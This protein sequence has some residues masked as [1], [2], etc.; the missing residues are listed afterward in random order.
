MKL[1]VFR[2]LAELCFFP[3]IRM[4]I[5]FCVSI[6]RGKNNTANYHS[7]EFFMRFFPPRSSFD[8]VFWMRQVETQGV[9]MFMGSVLS[10]LWT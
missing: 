2:V 3:F 5:L 8:D 6:S 4:F 1:H 7:D 10:D 9:L